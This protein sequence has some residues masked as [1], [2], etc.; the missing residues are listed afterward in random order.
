MKTRGLEFVPVQPITR[1]PRLAPRTRWADPDAV[2]QPT[3]PYSQHRMI[4]L[5]EMALNSRTDLAQYGIPCTRSAYPLLPWP[6]SR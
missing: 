3:R 6:K 2:L 5:V 1:L 4:K